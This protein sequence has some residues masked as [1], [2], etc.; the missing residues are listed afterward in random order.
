MK[1]GGKLMKWRG[2]KLNITPGRDEKAKIT[3]E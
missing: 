1:G 3:I 2:K